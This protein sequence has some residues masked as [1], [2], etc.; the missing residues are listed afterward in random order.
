[1]MKCSSLLNNVKVLSL[2]V[3]GKHVIY[4]NI[5]ISYFYGYTLFTPKNS[6]RHG[7]FQGQVNHPF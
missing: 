7:L 4:E 2:H 6:K 5:E 3:M 1:M